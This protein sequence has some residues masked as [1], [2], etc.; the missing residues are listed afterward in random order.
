VSPRWRVL[1]AEDDPQMRAWLRL[2][3]RSSGVQI[4]EVP[5]GQALLDRIADDDDAHVDAVI[6]DVRMPGPDGLK[7]LAMARTAGLDT[8]ALV[9]TA[10][11]DPGVVA[12]V[13]RLARTTLLP[14]PFDAG[15]LRTALRTLLAG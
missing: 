7:V 4:E 8:P 5:S 14:K 2:A 13:G 1:I 12:A 11:P 6:T 15:E 9:I 10:F 3:L